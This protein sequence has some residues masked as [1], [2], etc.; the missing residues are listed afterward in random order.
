MS[1][2]LSNQKLWK[3]VNERGEYFFE[4]K[5]DGVII[6]RLHVEEPTLSYLKKEGLI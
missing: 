3:L 6:V 1:K 4:I 2:Y 5:L